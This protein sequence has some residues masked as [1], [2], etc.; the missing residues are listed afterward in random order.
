[1]KIGLSC[2]G[3]VTHGKTKLSTGAKLDFLADGNNLRKNYDDIESDF[4]SIC[5]DTGHTNEVY[6]I[7]YKGV[8]NWEL[9]LNY[10][11]NYLETSLL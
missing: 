5:L 2:D 7:G 6:Y 1:M 4:K 11:G 10:F 8:Y 9:N 3:V